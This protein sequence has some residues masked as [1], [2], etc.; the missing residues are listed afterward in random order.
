MHSRALVVLGLLV[1]GL[2]VA[3]HF[4][5]EKKE[6]RVE[7]IQTHLAQRALFEGLTGADFPAL[8]A[9]VI[10]NIPRSEQM[11]FE[12]DGAGRWFMVDPVHW[13]AELGVLKLLFDTVMND[14]GVVVEDVSPAAAGLAPPTAVCN[15]E[16]EGRGSFTIEV[17]GPDLND[18]KMYVRTQAPGKPARILRANR[19]LQ[20]IFER[21]VPDYRNKAV[22]REE[23]RNV[24]EIWRSGPASLPVESRAIVGPAPPD[25]PNPLV[26]VQAPFETLELHAVD[27]QLGWRLEAPYQAAAD[28]QALGMVITT[29]CNLDV[30]DFLAEE[31]TNPALFG[32][33]RPELEVELKFI[34]GKRRRF[35]FARPPGMRQMPLETIGDLL[36]QQWVCKLEHKPQV[37]E[38]DPNVVL[39]SAGP[40]DVFFDRRLVRG[41]VAN[42][43][44]FELE[45][46]GRK[47]VFEQPDPGRWTLTGKASNGAPLEAAATDATLVENLFVR[48]RQVELGDLLPNWKGAPTF[49]AE[50]FEATRFGLTTGGSFAPAMWAGQGAPPEEEPPAWL[51][52]RDGDGI[53]AEAPT[54]LREELQRPG[55]AY[56]D[57]RLLDV[58]ELRL[59]RIELAH[60]GA[61]RAFERDPAN[62]QWSQVG[63]PGEARAFALVVDRLRA[64][65][66][67]ELVFGQGEPFVPGA[68]D[69]I[70]VRLVA[71]PEPGPRGAAGFERTYTVGRG[72]AQGDWY[73]DPAGR[74][75]R[76]FPGLFAEL[77]ALF[78]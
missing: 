25:V 3:R 41:E 12:R 31:I 69:A 24:V 75:A 42:V 51:F 20:A 67:L 70:E 7:E 39:L 74:L 8:R 18:S 49:V 11:R 47:L 62:G 38:V 1:A 27:A 57:R 33:D 64:I 55:E 37:F 58:D 63:A 73:L 35:Q 17:G 48:L 44:R 46:A 29:L 22:V 50:G 77:E 43:E 6:E 26:A 71:G 14:R 2:F 72:D 28:P 32:L 59:A 56:L 21:F 68:A 61:V 52:Q 76:L 60:E 78:D 66:A 54:S 15:F 16:F 13:P 40:V 5:G 45:A 4:L 34:D 9:V 65:K 36:N 30:T 23:P 10:D 19:A 53:W